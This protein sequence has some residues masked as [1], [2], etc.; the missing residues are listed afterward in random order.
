M[1][2]A[3]NQKSFENRKARYDYFIEDTTEA[4]IVLRGCEIKAVCDGQCNLKDSFIRIEN[5]E[6]WLYGAHIT[7]YE[8]AFNF[9]KPDP[10]RPR[11]LLMHKNEIR[12]LDSQVSEKGYSLIPTK[13]YFADNGKLK[14]EVALARGKKNYDKRESLAKKDAQR[15]IEREF[16]ERD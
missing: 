16:K 9:D 15:Q 8:K 12:K 3:F 1:N 5:G 2:T 13:M 10:T 14:I 11:K 4:G 6:A 7:Q